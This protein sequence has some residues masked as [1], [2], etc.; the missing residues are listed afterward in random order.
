MIQRYQIGDQP[1]AG[2][3]IR[4]ILTGGM[5]IVYV[6]DFTEGDLTMAMKTCDLELVLPGGGL[7]RIQTECLIWMLLPSHPNVVTAKWY[8]LDGGLPSLGMEYVPGGNLRQRLVNGRLSLEDALRTASQVCEGMR[9]IVEANGV[10]HRDLKPENILFDAD[11]VAKIT[12]FG[13][14]AAFDTRALLEAEPEDDGGRRSRGAGTAPYMAPEQFSSFDDV[15]T[16]ADVYSMGVV[17]Y[18]MLAGRRPFEDDSVAALERAHR[19]RPPPPLPDDVPER[20]R[21]LIMRCLAKDPGDRYASFD[22]LA[23][24]VAACC[25]DAGAA[26]LVAERHTLEAQESSLDSTAWNQRGYFFSQLHRYDDA[27]RAYRRGMEVMSAEEDVGNTLRTPGVDKVRPMR[28]ESLATLHNNLGATLLRMRRVEEGRAEF[29]AALEIVP[30]DS[31]ALL[32]LGQLA[33]Y[34]DGDVAGGLALMKRSTESEPGNYDILLKYVR[35]CHEAGEEA[36]YEAGLDE[37]LRGKAGDHPTFL[38]G[39]GSHLE[40]EL[41]TEFSL[42]CFDQ[43]LMADPDLA[44]AWFNKGVTLHRIGETAKAALH[45]RRALELNRDHGLARCYLGIIELEAGSLEEASWQLA[46]FLETSQ[47][48]AQANMIRM[49]FQSAEMG[50]PVESLLPMLSSPTFLRHLA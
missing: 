18:E 12:D 5:G 1:K 48:S 23:A 30:D 9:F 19:R 33:L 8:E 37:F 40:E 28:A 38:V 22:A 17:L 29:K 44:N 47:E 32:R 43:A 35:A 7:E 45:Y 3:V 14:A 25:R 36:A 34:E 20:V 16:R 27:V 21:T 39:V 26:H 2:L 50:L 6:L 31:T 13:L 46:T 10:V 4:E 41:G 15:E 11:G 49:L 42:R 24:E